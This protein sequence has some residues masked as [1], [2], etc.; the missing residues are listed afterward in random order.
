MD[1]CDNWGSLGAKMTMTTVI[2]IVLIIAV[3]SVATRFF[4]KRGQIWRSVPLIQVVS[5][6]RTPRHSAAAD[7]HFRHLAGFTV[8]LAFLLH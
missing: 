3:I 6:F 8:L 5:F 2:E 1:Q 7:F 4:I